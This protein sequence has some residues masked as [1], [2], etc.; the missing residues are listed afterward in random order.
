MVIFGGLM[1]VV[2]LYNIFLLLSLLSFAGMMEIIPNKGIRVFFCELR[3]GNGD[4]ILTLNTYLRH[5][6]IEEI[7]SDSI[8]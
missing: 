1:D 3:G 4:V 5:F 6:I 8:Y 2:G 7:I